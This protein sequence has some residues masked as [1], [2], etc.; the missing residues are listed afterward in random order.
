MVVEQQRQI[1]ATAEH[2]VVLEGR[3]IGTVVFPTAH[4]K[5]FLTASPA[6]RARRRVEEM[7]SRG[8]EVDAGRTLAELIERDERDSSRAASPLTMAD[9]AIP[10]DTDAISADEVVRRIL[11]LWRER[12][13]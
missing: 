7:R 3:D 8:L 6:E 1:S 12:Q 9:D 2:G 13:P 4:L 10:V 5:V 11:E